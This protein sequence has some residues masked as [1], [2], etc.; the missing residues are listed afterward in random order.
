M[1]KVYKNIINERIDK[2][3]IST[4]TDEEALCILTGIPV[5]EIKNSL[6]TYGLPE[7]VKFSSSIT[8]T[9]SQRKKLELIYHISKRIAISAFK[10]KINLNSSSKAG[11]YFKKELQF[12]NYE[13]FQIA[14][15]DSQNRIIKTEIVS[16]GTIN[17][18]PVYP[19]EIVKIVLNNNAN[20]VILAH[21]HPGGSKNPSSSDIEV[22]RKIIQA[23]KTISVSVIDHIIIADNTFISFA[24]KGLLNV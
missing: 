22:T 2:Y 6:E 11:E 20:S 4:L 13:V 14:L 23:L 15:L 21:N 9:K 12:L 18:A 19:R 7:L 24:E 5:P 8:I 16:K 1:E 10:E 3:G 17:E